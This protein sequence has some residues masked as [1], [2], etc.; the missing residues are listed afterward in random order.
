MNRKQ[1]GED[2]Y[3]IQKLMPLG[4]YFAL[5]STAIYPSPRESSRVPF[6]PVL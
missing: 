3:F 1:A 2:F 5:N 4:G 6:V